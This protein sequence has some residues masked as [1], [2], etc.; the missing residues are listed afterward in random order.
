MF[1][2]GKR[3]CCYQNWNGI[4]W[5][6]ETVAMEKWSKHCSLQLP[7]INEWVFFPH[8]LSF[9]FLKEGKRRAMGQ[10]RESDKEYR[11]KQDRK[12]EGG[13]W[14]QVWRGGLGGRTEVGVCVW[15]GSD[16]ALQMVSMNKIWPPTC[17]LQAHYFILCTPFLRPTI[18]TLNTSSSRTVRSFTLQIICAATRTLCHFKHSARSLV[19]FAYT[20]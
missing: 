14:R 5:N 2:P 11:L 6:R 16:Q 20:R 1:S 12:G 8:F 19:P 9:F 13:S 3:A 15:C 4:R 17:I 18:P 10:H 7:C